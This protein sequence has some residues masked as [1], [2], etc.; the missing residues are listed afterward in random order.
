MEILLGE[1]NDTLKLAPGVAEETREKL[2]KQ[3]EPYHV[4]DEVRHQGP[5]TTCEVPPIN[6]STIT[7]GTRILIKQPAGTT[8]DTGSDAD[9][10]CGGMERKEKWIEASVSVVHSDDPEDQ[11]IETD[12]SIHYGSHIVD[13]FSAEN[14]FYKD[15]VLHADFELED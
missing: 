4:K 9:A 1:L 13:E 7:P 2:L 6:I 15:G 10:R 8:Y 14:L 3:F 11:Y 12:E 5:R